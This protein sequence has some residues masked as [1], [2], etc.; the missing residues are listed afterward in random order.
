[1]QRLAKD[2]LEHCASIQG[3]GALLVLA[4]TGKL[5]IFPVLA[6]S[7]NTSQVLAISADDLMALDGFSKVLTDEAIG[8]LADRIDS[9]RALG[10]NSGQGPKVFELK[11]FPGAGRARKLWCALHINDDD[12]IV[13]EFESEEQPCC[14]SSPMHIPHSEHHD[15]LHSNEHPTESSDLQ[16]RFDRTLKINQRWRGQRILDPV[17]GA[18]R[19]MSRIQEQ[20]A[21]ATDIEHLFSIFADEIKEFTCYQ[22]VLVYQYDTVSSIRVLAEAMI[23]NCKDLPPGA[24][25]D[26]LEHCTELPRCDKE[27]F[28]HARGAQSVSILFREDVHFSRTIDLSS[29]YLRAPSSAQLQHLS[30]VAAQSLMTIP[31]S[32]MGKPWGAVS[33]YSYDPLGKRITFSARSVCRFV[34]DA[35]SQNIQRIEDESSLR[36]WSRI[37]AILAMPKDEEFS[38][39]LSHDLLQFFCADCGILSIETQ[40]RIIGQLEQP[41]EI[42]FI[43]EWLRLKR[44]ESVI[45]SVDIMHDFADLTYP[46]G[47]KGIAGMM[48]IPFTQNPAIFFVFFRR[49]QPQFHDDISDAWTDEQMA[50]ANIV[51]LLSENFTKASKDDEIDR[52]TKLLV[53]NAAHEIRTPLNAVLNYLEVAM[54]GPMN[55]R[56]KDTLHQSHLASRELLDSIRS[57]I[58]ICKTTTLC[59]PRGME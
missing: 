37:D 29:S 5:N 38:T 32:V 14:P 36:A 8:D 6:A 20:L 7:E 28:V 35:T 15:H 50:T 30:Q 22:R 47:F 57:L 23:S 51:C 27:Q 31:I 2:G 58:D 26:R 48:V 9:I 1:M 59:S 16:G 34:C 4:D 41:Q 45:A 24:K 49:K 52:L 17:M 42:L 3:Y 55:P 19:F 43:V 11:F 33:C 25:S 21:A 13:L 56:T 10:S 40:T 44:I 18:F 54:E 46:R 39:A 12:L 53:E